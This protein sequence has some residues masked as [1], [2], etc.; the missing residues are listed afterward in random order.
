[1]LLK[2]IGMAVGILMCQ[3]QLTEDQ[4]IAVLK[5]HSQQRNV[6]LRELARAL[7]EQTA[8]AE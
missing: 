6:K 3:R 8:A 5:T 2:P 1:M 4:A 7:V